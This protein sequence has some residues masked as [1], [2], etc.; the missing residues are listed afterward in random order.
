MA[1]PPTYVVIGSGVAGGIICQG[2][3]DHGAAKVTLIEAGP[4]VKMQDYRTWLELVTSGKAP[5]DPYQ[6]TAPD[7]D[8]VGPHDLVLPNSRL[9]VEGGTTLHWEGCCPRLAPEDFAKASACGIGVDWPFGYD[10]L[11]PFYEAAEAL[12]GVSADWQRSAVPRAKPLPLPAIQP[13]MIDRQLIGA[14]D[15]LGWSAEQ[16]PIAR[17]VVPYQGHAACQSTGTCRYCPVGGR[18]SGE[19]LISAL[20][21]H[22]RASVLRG[23]VTR[24]VMR[25]RRE[26]AGVTFRDTATGHDRLIEADHV[27]VCAGALESTKLLLASG[28]ADWPGG[29]GDGGGHL[30][31]NL[32]AH[33]LLKMRVGRT[34]NPDRVAQEIHFPSW[35]TREYDGAKYQKSGKVI[36]FPFGGPTV[37]ISRRIAEGQ[38]FKTIDAAVSGPA[39][40]LLAGLCEMNP[41]AGNRIELAT[42]KTKMGLPRTRIH[43]EWE[44]TSLQGAMAH[45]GTMAGLAR[46]MGWEPIDFQIDQSRGSRIGVRADHV[47]GTCRMS[48]HDTDGV[49][50]PDLRVHGTDNVWVCSNA[51]IPSPGAANPTITLAALALRLIAQFA[52]ATAGSTKPLT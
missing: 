43:F 23:V 16:I 39:E 42:G 2:L 21:T 33:P 26:A 1:L 46:K 41:A 27:I 28:T 22:P 8:N 19:Q 3:L 24:I 9:F 10:Y 31:R 11:E 6:D 47:T 49:V 5:Y 13:N 29:L 35:C 52:H 17:Y 30:G 15:A 12:I 20:H 34:L 36:I 50:D 25:H 38:S 7:C 44:A 51:V 45:Q 18:F 32:V 48:R 37:D 4:R 14:C 40:M